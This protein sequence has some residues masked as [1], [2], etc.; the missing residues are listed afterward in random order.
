MRRFNVSK[1]GEGVIL[2]ELISIS[3]MTKRSTEI[4]V[5]CVDR[6]GRRPH[7]RSHFIYDTHF[8]DMQRAIGIDKMLR[9]LRSTGSVQGLHKRWIYYNNV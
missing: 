4:I 8:S 9:E 3:W 2:R 1:M 6:T 5:C 7:S